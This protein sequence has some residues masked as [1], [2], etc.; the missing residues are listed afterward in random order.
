MAAYSDLS[1]L[2]NGNLG[3]LFERGKKDYRDRI[4]FEVLSPDLFTGKL[5]K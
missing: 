2:Q 1:A 4:T 5:P 3:L